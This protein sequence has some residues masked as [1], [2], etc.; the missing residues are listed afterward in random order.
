MSLEFQSRFYKRVAVNASR[1][2]DGVQLINFA[3]N[4]AA[5]TESQ[6]SADFFI[7]SFLC[8]NKLSCLKTY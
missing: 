3:V 8:E 1:G 5:P 2:L 4:K 7:Q 6:C